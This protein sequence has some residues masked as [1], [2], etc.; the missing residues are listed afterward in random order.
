MAHEH[1]AGACLQHGIKK[2]NLLNL[3]V[4]VR[5]EKELNRILKTCEHHTHSLFMY[6]Q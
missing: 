2:M 5:G 6:Q 4:K 1:G 3:S